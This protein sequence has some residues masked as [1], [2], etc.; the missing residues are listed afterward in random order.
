MKDKENRLREIQKFPVKEHDDL[1]DA[2]VIIKPKPS[3]RF[4]EAGVYAVATLFFALGMAEVVLIITGEIAIGG[5]A[6]LLCA[7]VLPWIAD[8]IARK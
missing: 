1:L 2:G 3:R 6:L 7:M 5:A 8:S 4:A